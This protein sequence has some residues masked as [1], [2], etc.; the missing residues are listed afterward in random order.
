MNEYKFIVTNSLI[1]NR[2]NTDVGEK[3]AFDMAF[4]ENR[5]YIIFGG[6]GVG[7]ST[8]LSELWIRVKLLTG[9]NFAPLHLPF[10][11]EVKRVR[12]QLKKPQPLKLEPKEW[13]DVSDNLFFRIDHALTSIHAPTY[14]PK[15]VRLH[16]RDPKIVIGSDL[17]GVG[18]DDKGISTIQRL[19]LRDPAD[20][21]FTGILADPLDQSRAINV[22]GGMEYL[23]GI[24]SR[25]TNPKLKFM[26][27]PFM[28]TY[29][30][31]VLSRNKMDMKVRDKLNLPQMTV[32]M[33]K[34][35]L[36]VAS[37][38]QVARQIKEWKQLDLIHPGRVELPSEVVR[39]L[40]NPKLVYEAEKIGI[41]DLVMYY[42]ELYA[43][44]EYWMDQ[45]GL[46]EQKRR[47]VFN[48][49]IPD[50]KI[51]SDLDILEEQAVG[52]H[53]KSA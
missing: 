50:E 23:N 30:N 33:A 8:I 32:R 47:F 22:R 26:L 52:E 31:F 46:P 41:F 10:D 39:R 25:I 9:S 51:Y 38:Q 48:I 49:F 27:R 1:D 36:I 28:L 18:D 35:D 34:R 53:I 5:G 44:M 16:P 19:A 21:D 15:R 43:H 11:Y 37:Q 14:N 3:L 17:I 2:G 45:L 6:A 7:K 42:Q 24:F 13:R 20:V 40:M 12:E 4:G 29:I